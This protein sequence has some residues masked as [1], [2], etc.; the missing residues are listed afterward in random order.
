MSPVGE[1]A[2]AVPLSLVPPENQ[3]LCRQWVIVLGQWLWAA[4]AGQVLAG[5]L[6]PHAG[7][8][9]PAASAAA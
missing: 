9:P 7:R 1:R 6:E 5:L 2:S 8:R 4:R 3:Q